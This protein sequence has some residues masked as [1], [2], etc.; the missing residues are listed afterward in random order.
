MWQCLA[1]L[2]NSL[3]S[4]YHGEILLFKADADGESDELRLLVLEEDRM[5]AGFVPLLAAP[6]EPCYIEPQSDTV[7]LTCKTS[8]IIF[9]V[10]PFSTVP[11]NLN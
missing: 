9:I 10:C 4:V 3:A 5:L 7:S 2:C 1:E 8:T 6:Q 11:R